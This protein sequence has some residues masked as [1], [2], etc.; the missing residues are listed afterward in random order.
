MQQEIEER[1]GKFVAFIQ[2]NE[3]IDDPFDDDLAIDQGIN[4]EALVDVWLVW[5]DVKREN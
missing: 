4:S 3:Q 5:D 1:N 2:K